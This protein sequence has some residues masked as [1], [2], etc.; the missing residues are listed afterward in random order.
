MKHSNPFAWSGGP[1]TKAIMICPHG[2]DFREFCP[3]CDVIPGRGI[4][5]GPTIDEQNAD[6]GGPDFSKLKLD[7]SRCCKHGC[8]R[9]YCQ[10]CSDEPEHTAAPWPLDI[11]QAHRELEAMREHPFVTKFQADWRGPVSAAPS[12]DAIPQG[13]LPSGSNERKGIPIAT[14]CLDY[15]PDAL[16]EIARLSRI[17]NDKHNPGQPLHWSRGKSNDHPDCM[18]RHFFQRGTVD[19]SG[20][21][22]VLHSTQM[23][24][25]ALAILQ[26][27]IEA[28]NAEAEALDR[29]G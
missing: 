8:Y 4:T 28:R 17:G 9:E 18:I 24:W 20:A 19:T 15:F 23:A 27:E 5:M 13:R 12:K 29:G 25:R 10:T 14:G 21:E 11:E 2:K 1:T 3:T 26:L 7:P 6:H 22:P 16:A